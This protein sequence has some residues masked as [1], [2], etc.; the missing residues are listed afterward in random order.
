MWVVCHGDM[1]ELASGLQGVNLEQ[2]T[3]YTKRKKHQA[4]RDG[5]KV[6]ATIMD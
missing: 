6:A 2:N 4:G 1:V 5:L 3:S